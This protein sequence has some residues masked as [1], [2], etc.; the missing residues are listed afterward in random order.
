M[1]NMSSWTD[2][3]LGDLAKRMDDG[4]DQVAR[5]FERFETRINLRFEEAERNVNYRFGEVEK[6]LD[7]VD[8]DIRDFR[9]DLLS[10]KNAMLASNTALIA[11]VLAA[12]L[13]LHFWG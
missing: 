6:R 12:V 2:E 13:S 3:R 11:T 8:A 10:V 9:A 4:F 5:R 1:R 7:R